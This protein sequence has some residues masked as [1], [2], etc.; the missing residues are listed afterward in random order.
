M[1]TEKILRQ[2]ELDV[3]MEWVTER[4][5]STAF[6]PR[7]DDVVHYAYQT[8]G[9]TQLTRAAIAKQLRL[10]PYYMMNSSQQR[11][12]HKSRR[13]R[14]IIA[15]SLGMLH[16]DI[17]FYAVVRDYET[18]K[19]YRGGFIV[20]KD[21][22]SKFL[23]VA[24]LDTNRNAD[25][26]IKALKHIFQQHMD[27]F[28][29]NGHKIKS[30]AFDR[31][32]SVMSNKVQQ[33]LEDHFISFH[34]FKYSSSKSKMAE[35]AIRLIRTD[36]KRMTLTNS[37]RRWWKLMDQVVDGL[38]SKF[39]IIK[40][41]RLQW[42]PKDVDKN[43]VDEYLNSLHKADPA[44]YFG[45]FEIAP[46][47]VNFKFPLGTFVRPK[48]I[49]TSSAVIGEKRSEIN[50]EKDTFV[51]EEQLPFVNAN[52]EIGNAYKCVNQR[53]GEVEIFD[54]NDLAKTTA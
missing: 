28:G 26:I 21:I 6:V 20:L 22:V 50:L 43:N 12:K 36:M 7:V 47:L 25:S 27:A 19:K 42:A 49:V 5:D 4:V 3:L 37:S 35:N 9:Y 29:P 48:L 30:I 13:H 24:L 15:N 33:F 1:A 16:G 39:I 8:L 17:G 31:E 2:Q 54:E 41:T 10:H 44:H 45:Q 32:T 51:V 14:P 34:A 46:Q 11:I 23:Y 52:L 40:K 18:P 38:N 53:S